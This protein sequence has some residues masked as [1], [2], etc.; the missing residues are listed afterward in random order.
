[1]SYHTTVLHDSYIPV[2]HKQGPGQSFRQPTLTGSG[3]LG[4]NAPGAG[5]A[6][7]APGVGATPTLAVTCAAQRARFILEPL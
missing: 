7:A 6:P 4:L 1:M 5:A 2:I 3:V